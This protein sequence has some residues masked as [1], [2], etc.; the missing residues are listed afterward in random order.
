MNTLL[1]KQSI[2]NALSTII[3]V[4]LLGLL[5]T[6]LIWPGSVAA[7]AKSAVSFV[8][9]AWIGEYT[10][11]SPISQ[12]QIIEM[13]DGSLVMQGEYLDENG[14]A[15]N[16][17]QYESSTVTFDIRW[18][19]DLA[20]AQAILPFSLVQPGS[21]P[22]AYVFSGVK[23][24]GEGELASAHLHY[25]GPD[26]DLLLS[27]RPIGGQTGQTVSIGLPES[28]TVESV[29]VNGQVATWAEHVLMWEAGGVS[30]LLSSPD[31]SL[32]DAISIAESLK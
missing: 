5:F 20:E 14:A 7:A 27:Q 16:I 21:L 8:Q 12:D 32:S 6:N 22:E 19:N 31:L 2:K 11:V 3:L 18:F 17:S 9:R 30:Y 28:Y 15:G 29:R 1:Q 26:G 25:S 23:V 24:F 10:S 13:E 4:G